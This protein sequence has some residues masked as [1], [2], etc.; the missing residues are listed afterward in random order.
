MKLQRNKHKW[1]I[2]RAEKLVKK[3]GCNP[4]IMYK[5]RAKQPIP[6]IKGAVIYT[7]R[8]E[9]KYTLQE[10]ADTFN[11]TPATASYWSERIREQLQMNDSQTIKILEYIK[12]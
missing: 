10:C 2:R 7:M 9:L 12:P 4:N 3:E 11:M 6:L 1:I 8:W 5:K